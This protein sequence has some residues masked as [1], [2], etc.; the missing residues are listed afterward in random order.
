MKTPRSE[1]LA[2]A[3]GTLPILMG[4]APFGLIYGVSARS[5]GLTISLGQAMSS[6]VF[7]GSAQFVTVQLLGA[8]ISAGVIF[9]T[10]CIINLRHALYSASLAPYMQRLS[11][12]WKLLLCY[13]LTDEAYAVAITR[14]QQSDESPHKHWFF[15]G[16]GLALWSAWQACTAVGLILG[17]NIPASWSLDFTLPLT[18]IA[19]VVPVLKRRVDLAVAI[20]AGLVAVLA[21]HLPLNSGLLVA[22]CASILAGSLMEVMYGKRTESNVV[23]EEMVVEGRKEAES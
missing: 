21:A 3:R 7:A 8:G 11:V 22:T 14:Y 1:F 19:L 10:A 23:G 13:L 17:A 6:I 2:G 18:F 12:G 16:T 15:L 9:V 5:A 4:A 20:I